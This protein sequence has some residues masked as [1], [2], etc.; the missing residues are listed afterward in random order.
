MEGQGNPWGQPASTRT[1]WTKGL[2]F[3]VPTVADA[4]GGPGGLDELEVLYWVGC[5]AAFDERNKQVARAV[6]TC[7]ARGRVR[8]AILGQEESCTGDPARRMGNDYVFQILAT[9][10]VETLEPL[11][12]GPADDRHRLPALLQHDR[13]RVRPARRR[14]TGSSTTRRTSRDCSRTG[15]CG[16]RDG[17]TPAAA[18]AR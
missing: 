1:D 3:E 10:N 6:A 7:L 18:G 9:G 16:S 4:G 13:Q 5:A 2:P 17:R 14:R 11:R 12:D 15:G 8:F